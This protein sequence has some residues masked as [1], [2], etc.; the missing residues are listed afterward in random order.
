MDAWVAQRLGSGPDPGIRDQVPHQAP[1][2]EPAS[3]S[4]CGSAS[5]CV[6][7]S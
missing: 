4:A 1:S 2:E 5:L 7:L 3:P 6:P